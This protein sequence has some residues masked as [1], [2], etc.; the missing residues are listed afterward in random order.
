MPASVVASP[1]RNSHMAVGTGSRIAALA[2]ESLQTEV[3][4]K[5][6]TSATYFGGTERYASFFSRGDV[7]SQNRD[8]REAGILTAATAG[9]LI[10][11]Y[12]TAQPIEINQTDTMTVSATITHQ[13]GTK[14]PE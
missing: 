6:I 8:I 11:R 10:C 2:D 7:G 9:Q 12:T 4:R 14:I 1:T 3:G 5:A 13:N